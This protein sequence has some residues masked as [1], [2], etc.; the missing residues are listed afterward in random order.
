MGVS[1]KSNWA[2][3]ALACMEDVWDD[4]QRSMGMLG[5]CSVSYIE[6]PT[7]PL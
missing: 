2:A 3:V 4:Y 1:T 6:P 7:T 5:V